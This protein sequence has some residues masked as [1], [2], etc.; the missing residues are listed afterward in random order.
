MP[1]EEREQRLGSSA[2]LEHRTFPTV[3]GA[4]R[5]TGGLGVFALPGP[6]AS[7]S[8][9]RPRRD[10]FSAGFRPVDLGPVR[11]GCAGNRLA[12][13]NRCHR[14]RRPDHRYFPGA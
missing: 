3:A 7:A 6:F 5:N 14:C 4:I 8:N 1:V 9:R 10:Q 11:P 2:S 12:C 13:F